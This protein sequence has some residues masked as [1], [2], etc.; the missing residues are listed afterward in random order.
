TS[1][2][3]TEI[4][5]HLVNLHVSDGKPLEDAVRAALRELRGTYAIA[6]LSKHEAGKIVVAKSASPLVLGLSDGETFCGSDVPALLPYTRSMI[7]LEDGEMAL[8][9]RGGVTISNLDGNVV[10]RDAV[11]IDW[12]PM[13]AEKAGFKHFMLKEI[14]EQPRAIEDTL[15]GRLN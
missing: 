2:T 11:H 7:F 6:V 10:E 5:A 8:L 15:R 3:D 1:D 12:S 14:H 9:T 4:V 13:M